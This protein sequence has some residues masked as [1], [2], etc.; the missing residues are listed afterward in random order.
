MSEKTRKE[1]Q[2]PD[3]LVLV[4]PG[5]HK[6]ELTVTDSGNLNVSLKKGVTEDADPD[7]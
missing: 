2:V 4:S 7:A 5:G 3:K 6:Y 1:S